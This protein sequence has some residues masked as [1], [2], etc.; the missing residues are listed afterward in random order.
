VTNLHPILASLGFRRC[1]APVEMMHSRHG[2]FDEAC[3][4]VIASDTVRE[5][6]RLT[7]RS[8]DIRDSA[9]VL[10]FAYCDRFLSKRTSGWAVCSHS[11]TGTT[12][13]IAVTMR[14]ERCSMVNL[15]PRSAS[16]ATEVMKAIVRANQNNAGVYGAVTRIGRMAVGQTVFLRAATEI[17]ERG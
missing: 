2:I 14:D 1:G 5:I 4:S 13:A 12:R 17:R 9:R 7:G 16:I 11:A 6:G 3:I 10:S 15:D 8:L